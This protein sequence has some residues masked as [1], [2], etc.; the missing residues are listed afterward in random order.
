MHKSRVQLLYVKKIF[1][2]K[3]ERREREREKGGEGKSQ[4]STV[5]K[6]TASRATLP[7]PSLPRQ[8]VVHYHSSALSGSMFTHREE[9]NNN[10]IIV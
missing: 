3:G 1:K 7:C 8:T 5:T 10:R 6:E 2:F 4:G 9:E